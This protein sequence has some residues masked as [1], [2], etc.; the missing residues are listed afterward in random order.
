VAKGPGKSQ[1]A[2][3]HRKLGRVDAV[4][5][6]KEYWKAALERLKVLLECENT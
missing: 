6:T 1:V 4:A 2:V 3:E 5:K